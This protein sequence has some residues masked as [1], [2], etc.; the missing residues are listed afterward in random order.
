MAKRKHLDHDYDLPPLELL[1]TPRPEQLDLLDGLHHA[2]DYAPNEFA[3]DFF[4]E[5]A[6]LPD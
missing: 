3:D 5:I 2:P 6:P 4:V 1:R